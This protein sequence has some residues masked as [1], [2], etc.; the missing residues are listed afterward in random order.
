MAG[1]REALTSW[2]MWISSEVTKA[3][4]DGSS[5]SPQRIPRN[6]TDR[7]DV[8]LANNLQQSWAQMW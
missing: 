4:L 3:F 6:S 7:L 1:L 2:M 8:E 5:N